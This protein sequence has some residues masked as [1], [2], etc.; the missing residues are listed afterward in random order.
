MNVLAQFASPDFRRDP[1]PFLK[2][3]RDNDPVHRTSMGFHLISRHA[4][5]QAMQ[6]GVGEV[7]RSP[8]RELLAQRYA[9]AM[10][11]P[12]MAFRLDT[13]L[14]K[15][16]PEHTRLRRL[17]ARDFTPKRVADLRERIGLSCD[18][19]LDSI[20][21]P[22]R[23]GEVVDLHAELSKALTIKV[24]ADLI[25]VP[26]SDHG[27][28]TSFVTDFVAAFVG[29]SEEMMTLADQHTKLL[30]EYFQGMIDERRREPR[31]DLVSA[32]VAERDDTLS[33]DEVISMLWLLWIAGFETTAASIDHGVLAM[34]G[35]PDQRGWLT[36]D[37]AAATAFT[38]EVLRHS[39][40][41]LFSPVPRLAD[42]PVTFGEIE[43]PAGSDVRPVF[44]AANRDPAAFAD[45]DRFD[46]GRDTSATVAF[47]HGIHHCIGSFLA[48]AEISISL[49]R[50]QARFP[51]L[52]LGE[53]PEWGTAL[54]M[55][56]PVTLPVAL[57]TSR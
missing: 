33:D 11:H 56:A 5:V 34:I 35:N 43:L 50:L 23:D 54:P 30:R 36:R 12:S 44:A 46:P 2:W 21:E 37:A 53:Q 24:I 25:G 29:M 19:L 16:P 47:G 40:P 57:D 48:R 20:E 38:D 51:A 7:F 15:N 42:R 8:D 4:D 14:Q 10:R 45:P 55:Y 27:W 32:L 39:G 22:L 41:A 3:L 31:Q 49:A 28:L 9:D 52:V 6:R 13:M 26:E 17:V 18:R 1:Y